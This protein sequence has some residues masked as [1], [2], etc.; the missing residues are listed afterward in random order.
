MRRLLLLAGV[1]V[2]V[3]GYLFLFELPSRRSESER[4]AR[5]SRVFDLDPASIRTIRRQ[6]GM[7]SLQLAF[8]GSEWRML[9][10]R[11]EPAE[12][13]RVVDFLTEL[14]SVERFR[15]IDESGENALQF[16]LGQ[17]SESRVILELEGATNVS[18]EIG[19]LTPTEEGCY[20]RILGQEAVDV[21]DATL[22]R[23][24]ERAPSEFRRTRLWAFTDSTVVRIGLRSPNA[25][26]SAIKDS[27]GLWHDESDP[28]VELRQWMVDDLVYQLVRSEIRGFER[29]ALP[30]DGFAAYGLDSA[31]YAI[32]W[33]NA[34]GASGTLQLGSEAVQP[35][36]LFARRDQEDSVLLL[37]GQL[38]NLAVLPQAEW[39]DHNPI[40]ENF[41]AIREIEVVLE[42]GQRALGRGPRGFDLATVVAP[43]SSRTAADSHIA[44]RNV[45]YG[46]GRLDVLGE[47]DIGAGQSVQSS[48]ERWAATVHLRWADHERLV[49]LGWN[50]SGT[51]HWIQ[52][53]DVP[54]LYQVDRGLFFRLQGWVSGAQG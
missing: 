24:A 25:S 51:T 21:A 27:R 9:A 52:I 50:G 47:L 13:Q 35:G 7:N 46:I 42:D 45:Y 30:D 19:N 3:A 31:V 1:C 16:G 18:L 29:E 20:Y 36:L 32:D 17:L 10:P 11:Q 40:D 37:S 23:L 15:R 8:D 4:Q 5:E 43:G 39:I 6:S 34:E 22:R 12:T 48:L 49:R 2:V 33:A 41:K 26:W 44:L 53:D 14:A 54:R 28:S 38:M